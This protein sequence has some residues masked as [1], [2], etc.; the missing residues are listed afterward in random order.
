MP[1]AR[2][3]SAVVAK[4]CAASSVIWRLVHRGLKLSGASKQRRSSSR[5]AG[6]A[7]SAM[8]MRWHSLGVPLKWV[9]I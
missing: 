9:W 1:A 6:S 8:S 4:A 5:W 2:S 7:S 3:N